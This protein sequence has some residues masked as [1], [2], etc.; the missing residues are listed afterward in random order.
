MA[1]QIEQL[2]PYRI[3]AILGRGGMGTVY[4]AK[5]QDTGETAA[6][7]V[8]AAS[9]AREEGFR[10][11]FEAEI[12]TLRK[13]RHPHIVRLFGYGEQDDLLFYAMEMVDGPSLEAEL[14]KGR[15]FSWRETIHVGVDICKALKHAHDR[16][17][18]HR[19]IKPANLLITKTGAVKLSDFGI[20]K[21]FG[22]SGM[23]VIGGVVGTAEFMAPEQADGRPVGHRCD[24]YSLGAV[25]YTLLAGR[26]PFVAGSVPELLQMQRFAEPELIRRFNADAPEEL[27]TIVMQLLEKDAERRIANATLLARRLEATSHGLA[28]RQRRAEEASGSPASVDEPR[29]AADMA[30]RLSQGEGTIESQEAPDVDPHG[31]TRAATESPPAPS[32]DPLA[33]THATGPQQQAAPDEAAAS[34]PEDAA[35]TRFTMVDEEEEE[36]ADS[37][38]A[39]HQASWISPQTLMLCVALVA[40]GLIAWYFLEPPAAATLIDRI[41][42]AVDADGDDG[43]LRVAGDVEAFLRYYPADR[44]CTQMER[45]RRQIELLQMERRYKV[46]ARLSRSD[47]LSPVEGA[48]LEAITLADSDPPACRAKLRHLLA[49]YED[50]AHGWDRGAALCLRLARRQLDQ[51]EESAKHYVEEHL[52]V[53]NER[54]ERADGLSKTDPAAAQAMRQAVVDLYADKPWATPAVQRAADAI[55]VAES[56]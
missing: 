12:N 41:D 32:V 18:V 40:V 43:L 36:D 24:L 53:L 54:L 3:G 30:F 29:A 25:L 15:Q 14:K 51:L 55:R 10:E 7:K 56:K 38:Y 49:L 8:L 23:T 34:S 6:V 26:P 46:R 37:F 45:Y 1:I 20:A 47:G 5:N 39:T 21:L 48:Y 31:V 13:L 11:R 28:R 44:R 50:P 19:D 42:T 33:A 22:A 52:A 2:G 4:A 16:G 17:V 27:E 9:F 35:A